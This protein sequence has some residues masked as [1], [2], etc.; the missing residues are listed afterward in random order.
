MDAG[1]VGVE[2]FEKFLTYDNQI[3]VYGCRLSDLT[4]TGAVLSGGWIPSCPDARVERVIHS[5]TEMEI[6]LQAKESGFLKCVHVILSQKGND[7]S[8][9]ADWVA[10]ATA[11]HDYGFD[12]SQECNRENF[13]G[14]ELATGP[15]GEDWDKGYG[16]AKLYYRR[17]RTLDI[18]IDDNVEGSDC[19]SLVRVCV[20]PPKNV[21]GEDIRVGLH[22]VNDDDSYGGFI[23]DKALKDVGNGQFRVDFTLGEVVQSVC[24]EQRC[25]YRFFPVVFFAPDGSYDS[26]YFKTEFGFATANRL[27]VQL[28]DSNLENL[29]TAVEA[30]KCG[31][32]IFKRLGRGAMGEVWEVEDVNLGGPHLA[33]KVFNPQNRDNRDELRERFSREARVLHEISREVIRSNVR[34]PRIHRYVKSSQLGSPFYVMDL[35]VNPKGRP[36]SLDEVW[37]ECPKLFDEGHMAMWFEEVCCELAVLH[38]CGCLHRDIK[39][40]NILLDEDGHAVITDFG[41]ANI[42]AGDFAKDERNDITIVGMHEREQVGTRKY[43]AP[44][45]LRGKPASKASDIYAL[46]VTFMNLLFDD[47]YGQDDYPPDEE[48]FND[49]GDCG[50]KWFRALKSMLSPNPGKRPQSVDECLQIFNGD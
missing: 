27:I 42:L 24:Q 41:T 48:K 30:L 23:L 49:W 33:L 21:S 2:T 10:C 20:R 18:T 44:E 16:V 3:I 7:I 35:V 15:E 37:K 39:P 11:D 4:I 40:A 19:S 6:Q 34:L 17:L 8:A 47:T 43:W 36:C 26:A 5:G 1:V 38:R 32:R 28:S 14:L 50:G 31:Y 29:K 12:L 13:D 25:Q 22:W 9:R 45:L 46:G